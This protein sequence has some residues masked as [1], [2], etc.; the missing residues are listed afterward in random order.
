[1]LVFRTASS[2]PKLPELTTLQTDF[3]LHTEWATLLLQ[4]KRLTLVLTVLGLLLL[5]VQRLLL[6]LREDLLPLLKAKRLL[7]SLPM[8]KLLSE[9]LPESL[10]ELSNWALPDNLLLLS[11]H[12]RLPSKLL[13]ELQPSRL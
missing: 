9:L 2:L 11:A 3:L 6:L 12:Q 10:W 4:G 7:S 13:R 1:M 8:I 5:S